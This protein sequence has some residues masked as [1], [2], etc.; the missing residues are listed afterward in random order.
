[1]RVGYKEQTYRKC[2]D[3]IESDGGN[4]R[5]GEGQRRYRGVVLRTT[6]ALLVVDMPSEVTVDESARLVTGE[7]V[8]V[9]ARHAELNRHNE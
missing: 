9:T 4:L 1:M 2:S 8:R 6:Y 7:G 3:E 5:P